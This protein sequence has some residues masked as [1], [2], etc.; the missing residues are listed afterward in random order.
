MTKQK[1]YWKSF[2]DLEDD[3]KVNAL[4][5]K[6]F[7]EHLPI[8]LKS[9]DSALE[10]ESNTSRRDF[11]KLMGFSTAAATLAACQGPVKKS[12]PYVVQP[13][14]VKPGVA[15]YYASTY[16][17]GHDFASILVRTREG[18]PIKIEPNKLSKSFGHPNARVQGSLLGLYDNDVLRGPKQNG[19]STNWKEIDSSIK[20]KLEDASARAEKIVILTSTLLSPT[21]KKLIGEFKAK[22]PSTELVQYN[23]LANVGAVQAYKSM[24]GLEALP[25]YDFTKADTIISFGA[26]FLGD[27][28]G[29][30][31]QADYAKRR[32]P[33]QKLSRHIQLEGN[34]SLTGANADWRIP[35]KP[36]KQAKIP[37]CPI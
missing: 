34:M 30:N 15:N 31:V 33:D 4:K 26:D 17:D 13:D 11:L 25:T 18:R 24:F 6:E 5:N 20:Q 19:I 22:Y 14:Q 8:A 2:V 23:A 1:T 16:Y 10:Q 12:I 36:S 27:W 32:N 9:D 7:T 28:Y 21:T 3:P 35:T 29:G 37:C